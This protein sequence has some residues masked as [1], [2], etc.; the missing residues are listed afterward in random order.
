[1]L[2]TRTQ[3]DTRIPHGLS[4]LTYFIVIIEPPAL[5]MDMEPDSWNRPAFLTHGGC[6]ELDGDHGADRSLNP[7][8]PFYSCSPTRVRQRSWGEGSNSKIS[9]RTLVKLPQRGGGEVCPEERLH[10][11]NNNNNNYY[12][13]G[14]AMEQQLVV[15]SA[16]GVAKNFSLNQRKKQAWRRT[17][18]ERTARGSEIGAYFNPS[19]TQSAWASR[20]GILILLPEAD[21]DE[22]GGAQEKRRKKEEKSN[23]ET[24]KCAHPEIGRHG[25]QCRGYRGTP[26][27][28]GWSAMGAWTGVDRGR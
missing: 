16:F 19:T 15:L 21:Q 6:L 5:V 11:N 22:R 12:Y 9:D 18:R 28:A 3:D 26:R 23:R 1:M 20:R 27:R 4:L 14:R 25:P 10:G 17:R 8:R 2:Q 24:R 7:S 13:W